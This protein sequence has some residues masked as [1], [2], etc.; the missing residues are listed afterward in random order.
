MFLSYS[1]ENSN[2]N[3]LSSLTEIKIYVRRKKTDELPQDVT[4]STEQLEKIYLSATVQEIYIMYI[5]D[6]RYNQNDLLRQRHAAVIVS[7]EHEMTV[8]RELETTSKL[9]QL[10]DFQIPSI[11][12]IERESFR[13][14]KG[15]SVTLLENVDREILENQYQTK[16]MD[17]L[18]AHK[19]LY[20]EPVDIFLRTMQQQKIAQS[21]LLFETDKILDS[22]LQL[23]VETNN[24]TVCKDIFL[25][26]SSGFLGTY[27]LEELLKQTDADIYCLVRSIPSTNTSQ[28]RIFYLHGDLTLPQLG[29]DD[30][31]YSMLVSKVRSIYH[32]GAAINFIKSYNEHRPENVLGTL[33]I[34]KLACVANCRIN[35]IS[36]LNVSNRSTKSGYV[37][38]KLVAECL[39]EQASER[40]L[41]ISIFRPGKIPGFHHYLVYCSLILYE[42]GY[43]SWS[44]CTGDFNKRDW[45]TL[46]LSSVTAFGLAP[47]TDRT[48]IMTPVDH[49]AKS[50]VELGES[51]ETVKRTINLSETYAVTFKAI[52][53]EIC[54]QRFMQP[55]FHDVTEWRQKLDE[56][57]TMDSQLL[58]GLQLF[59]TALTDPSSEVTTATVGTESDLNLPLFVKALLRN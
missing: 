23:S 52:W 21:L 35:Y 15:S 40:G 16:I 44:T 39:L 32:C 25:T 33:E 18:L 1:S 17:I 5:T 10:H 6:P 28:S 3:R 53:T 26:G 7:Q 12:L 14:A 58:H 43:I 37:Q 41:R 2:I 4:I 42:I 46:L 20:E 34:I 30:Y 49:M 50:I 36:T 48:F 56:W 54:R 57:L 51:E 59:S 19:N 11:V 27:L 45:I 47:E 55:Y 13:I 22:A 31:Q 8:L 9:K 38:S 29:L 24:K